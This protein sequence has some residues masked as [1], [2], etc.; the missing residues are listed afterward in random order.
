MKENSPLKKMGSLRKQSRL[1]EQEN[2]QSPPK[3]GL[4]PQKQAR[5]KLFGKKSLTEDEYMLRSFVAV[6]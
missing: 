6:S 5:A 3:Q 4:S 1:V 2:Q